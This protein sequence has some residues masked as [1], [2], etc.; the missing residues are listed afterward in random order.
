MPF[1]EFDRQMMFRALTLAKRGMGYVS[2]NPLVGCVIVSASGELLGE[3]AHLEFGGPHAEPNAIADAKARGYSVNGATAYVTL[4]PHSHQSKTPPCTKL[5]IEKRI[6]RCVVAMQDPN[7]NVNGAGIREMREAGIQV[8]V[9]LLS[10]DARELN[11]F[12]IKHIATGSP[13]VTIKLAASLDGRSALESG[14]SKWITSEASRK[15]VH[16]LRAEHDAVLV[17]TRTALA[18]D[19]ALTVRLAN[20]TRSGLRQPARIVLDT[21]LELPHAL[22]L[23]TDEERG[24][25]ILVTTASAAASRGEGYTSLG[26]ELL[27][28]G[29]I[30]NRIDLPQLLRALGA[31]G[32]ASVLV[33]AG[34]SLAAS[35]VQ[36]RLF[37]EL[38]IFYGPILLGG[39][40]KPTIGPLG[41]ETLSHA[42]QM[43][44]K[45]VEQIEGS[46]DVMM[47]FR[48]R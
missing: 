32:V 13:F 5:L 18:D 47:R 3:G 44:M 23:F 46:D 40:A 26:I 31:R 17:G 6:A 14:E 2:P 7:P 28:I 34:P 45:G 27:T 12:F 41:L 19:P 20:R 43:M 1:T 39:D 42:P 35:F 48:P 30:N 25:T 10:E 33:E 21:R 4:E 24:K 22:K 15:K 38:L 11:R 36:E 29:A 37:D 8:D 16:D 9:G